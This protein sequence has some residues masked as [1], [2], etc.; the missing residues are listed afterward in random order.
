MGEDFESDPGYQFL[1]ISKE[2][3]IQFASQSFDSKKNCWV[4]DEEEGGYIYQWSFYRF[5]GSVLDRL[6][7]GMALN[8]W[9]IPPNFDRNLLPYGSRFLTIAENP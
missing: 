3:R 9:W 8:F 7:L 1:G 6:L 5:F 4:P 2:E